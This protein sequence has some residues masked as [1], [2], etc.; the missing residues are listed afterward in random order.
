MTQVRVLGKPVEIE[1]TGTGWLKRQLPPEE[2][3]FVTRARLEW[4]FPISLAADRTE[5][6]VALGPKRSEEPYSREDQDLLEGITASLGLLLERSAAPTA[7]RESFEELWS[8]YCPRG[9]VLRMTERISCIGDV[10]H[11]RECGPRLCS[12]MRRS[13][14]LNVCLLK[15]LVKSGRDRPMNTEREE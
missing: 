5:A 3:E 1:Q 15:G 9:G 6:L 10:R 12:S 14:A 2:S 4:I 7:V 8:F 11:F 13:P